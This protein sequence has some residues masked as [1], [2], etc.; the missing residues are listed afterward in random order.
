[1]NKDDNK[2]NIQ[3]FSDKIATL[4]GALADVAANINSTT[5]FQNNE[6]LLNRISEI[7][8]SILILE[9]DIE[10]LSENYKDIKETHR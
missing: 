3:D 4:N 5:V 2:I 7:E 10:K 1:M 8:K 6:R 9:K